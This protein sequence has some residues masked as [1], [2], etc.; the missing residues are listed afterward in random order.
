MDNPDLATDLAN[1]IRASMAPK[2]S[3]ETSAATEKSDESTPET[4]APA[5]GK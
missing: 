4:P 5:E 3:P 2:P 1:R